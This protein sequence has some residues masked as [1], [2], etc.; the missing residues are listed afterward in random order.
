MLNV[1]FITVTQW[2]ARLRK[3]DRGEVSLEY[4]LVGGLMAAAII[5]G[6]TVLQPELKQ[7]FT[8]IGTDITNSLSQAF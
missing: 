2:A 3:D 4:A 8:D 7:W 1:I 6:L 5:A